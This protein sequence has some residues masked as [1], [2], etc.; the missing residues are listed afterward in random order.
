[1]E[2]NLSQNDTVLKVVQAWGWNQE[3]SL[4]SRNVLKIPQ[5][6]ARISARTYLLFRRVFG[7]RISLH[8]G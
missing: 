7:G 8:K 4:N 2:A 5:K 6:R 3:K 1:M